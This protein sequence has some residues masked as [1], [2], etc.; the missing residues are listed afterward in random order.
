MHELFSNDRMT[1]SDLPD[2]S[3]VTYEKLKTS[4]RLYSM[5]MAA[6]GTGVLF[7]ILL[8]PLLLTGWLFSIRHLLLFFASAAVYFILRLFI[9]YYGYG[10][11]GYAIRQHDIVYRS[12][13]WWKHYIYLPKSRVQHVEIKKSPF[14]DAFDIA[15]LKIYT[16]GGSGSDLTIPGLDPTLALRIKEEL[17]QQIYYDVEE[18]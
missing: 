13:I 18:E 8:W 10:H 11:K 1:L 16:A 3:T 17:L 6:I 14:E 4:Y 5:L 2:V 12:G 7:F 15:R 9:K